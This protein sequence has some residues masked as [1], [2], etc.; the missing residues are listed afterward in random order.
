MIQSC[1]EN[2]LDKNKWAD[3]DAGGWTIQVM[4]LVI[5]NFAGVQTDEAA[6][7]FTY[8][9]LKDF[10]VKQS[11]KQWRHLVKVVNK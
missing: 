1:L 2:H 6:R 3:R 8:I 10:K 4:I 5:C 9:N 11:M 7:L